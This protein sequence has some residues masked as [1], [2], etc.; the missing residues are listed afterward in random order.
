MRQKLGWKQY[1]R[2]QQKQRGKTATVQRLLLRDT[3]AADLLFLAAVYFLVIR[4][5]DVS[6][7]TV[8]TGVSRMQCR[9]RIYLDPKK[10]SDIFYDK[11]RSRICTSGACI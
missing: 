10:N 11:V 4:H 9:R 3:H 5:L 2:G 7:N 8:L 6:W 1:C